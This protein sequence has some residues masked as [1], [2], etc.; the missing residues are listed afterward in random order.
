MKLLS[1]R[2]YYQIQPCKQAERD[3]DNRGILGSMAQWG[4]QRLNNNVIIVKD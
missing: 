3:F 4:K 1:R 2:G